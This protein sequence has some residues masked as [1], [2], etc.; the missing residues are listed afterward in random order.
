MEW[1]S[2]T[3]KPPESAFSFRIPT[4]RWFSYGPRTHGAV[5]A[6]PPHPRRFPRLGLSRRGQ[7]LGHDLRVGLSVEPDPV[8][9]SDVRDFLAQ[10]GVPGGSISARGFGKTQPAASN[11]TPEGRQQNRR[12]E[13]VVTGE[14]IGTTVAGA[15]GSPR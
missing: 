3:G 12:V 13:L 4:A 6:K 7:E 5:W 15:S 10:Q 1:A 11:D 2:S 14:T 8:E 9:R